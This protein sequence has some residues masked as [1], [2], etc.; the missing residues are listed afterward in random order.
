[1]VALY[2]GLQLQL[3]V[4]MNAALELEK[5]V[6]PDK[7][8]VPAGIFYYRMQDPMLERG[9]E[10]SPAQINREILKKLKLDGLVNSDDEIVRSMDRGL[11]TGEKKSSDVIPV[12]YT[13][14][15]F[16]RYSAVAQRRQF[17]ELSAFV[18]EKMRDIGR[19]ILSGETDAEPYERKGRTACDYCTYREV[20]G[21][22]AKVPG[23]KFRRLREYKPEDIWKKIGEE[24]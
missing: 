15:G 23:T 12:S 6:Y 3:V 10:A 22:D 16:S 24:A 2:Y 8:I 5:R 9:E 18:N 11:G 20:C 7:D 19:R 4:Y 17:E 13:K 21:F 14:S 1:M